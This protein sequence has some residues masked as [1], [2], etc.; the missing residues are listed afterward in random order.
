M[1]DEMRDKDIESAL[2][3]KER[4]IAAFVR[5]AWTAAQA[6][7][8]YRA[9][10]DRDLKAVART[11]YD[12]ARA[13]YGAEYVDLGAHV[14]FGGTAFEPTRDTSPGVEAHTWGM[15]AAAEIAQGRVA[16]W[17]APAIY[18]RNGRL[19]RGWGFKNLAGAAWL[20]FVLLLTA[21]KGDQRCENPDCPD[22]NPVIVRAP[23]TTGPRRKYCS[24]GCR[25][26]AHYVSKTKPRRRAS[27]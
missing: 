27:R 20:Q 12:Y 21:D 15:N 24:D 23:G 17:C 5:E 4:G 6:W 25:L 11:D 16:A 14:G 26:H 19:E 9:A 2:R 3:F 10:Q 8:F 13:I 7:K 1:T 18:R 22:D